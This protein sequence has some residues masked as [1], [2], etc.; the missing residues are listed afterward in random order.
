MQRFFGLTRQWEGW[1]KPETPHFSLH[2]YKRRKAG[3]SDPIGQLLSAMLVAQQ[4]NV[5][6]Q[7]GTK[8]LLYGVVAVGVIWSFIVLDEK[9]YSVSQDFNTKDKDE[10]IRVVSI[11][12]ETRRRI[13]AEIQSNQ[14]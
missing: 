10:F 5:E 13:E 1:Q 4:R 3:N 8:R 6:T 11:L 2:E 14:S 12:Y 9:D 7:N